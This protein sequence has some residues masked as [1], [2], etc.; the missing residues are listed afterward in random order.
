MKYTTYFYRQPAN[1][2]RSAYCFA[3]PTL[4]FSTLEEARSFAQEAGSATQFETGSFRIASDDCKINEHWIRDGSAW[5][6]VPNRYNR[7]SARRR[8]TML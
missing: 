3:D 7:R 5:K 6:L 8:I 4:E 1:S 2:T